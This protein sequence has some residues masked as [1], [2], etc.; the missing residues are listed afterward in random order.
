MASQKHGRP[1]GLGVS[2]VFC[3]RIHG[4]M[5]G[6]GESKRRGREK[7]EREVGRDG[8]GWREVGIRKEGRGKD[9]GREGEGW[10]EGR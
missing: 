1:F 10:R 8:E 3:S 9:G 2:R 7:E 5:N 4:N 6:K